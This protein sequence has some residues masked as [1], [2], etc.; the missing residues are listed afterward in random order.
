M[1]DVARAFRH[2]AEVCYFNNDMVG[3]IC[4]SIGAVPMPRRCR[5]RRCWRARQPN[6]AAS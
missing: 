1:L 3:M 6:S 2:S 4:D 5:R